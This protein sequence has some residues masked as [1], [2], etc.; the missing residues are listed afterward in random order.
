MMHDNNHKFSPEIF[1]PYTNNNEIKINR[2]NQNVNYRCVCVYISTI[3][4]HIQQSIEC[5][6]E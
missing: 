1:H 6:S 2:V 4:I 5:A 3:E